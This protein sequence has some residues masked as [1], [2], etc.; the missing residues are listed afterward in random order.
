MIS[1]F[2][3]IF[4]I[5]TDYISDIFKEEVEITEKIDGSQFIFGR[6]NGEIFFRSKGATLFIDNPEKM[7]AEAIDYVVGISDIIRDNTV[8][9]CE[10]LKKP[11]H[12][13]L[14]YDRIPRNHLA[15]FGVSDSNKNFFEEIDFYATYHSI[16]RAPILYRGKVDGIEMF[17]E[18]LNTESYLGGTKIEG[19]VVKNYHRPFLLGGQPIPLMA[20]KYVSEAFKEIHQKR[21][22]GENT[23]KGRFEIF[24][25][26]FRSEA[27]WEK[28][29]QHLRDIGALEN[30]PRD[31][32]KL[33]KEI[34][35]DI[36]DEERDAIL[37]FLWKEFSPEILRCA[38]RGF[39]E[40]YKER[41]LSR[42]LKQARHRLPEAKDDK[43]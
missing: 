9:Y 25:T 24:K 26:Q 43:R 11:K 41:L 23:G 19:V 4:A 16:D 20:G 28:A 18:L 31:I 7:F 33:I 42:A 3:K 38:T 12:N 8:F 6:V 34:K 2:P 5:G 17:E 29:I 40:W 10:Y 37:K 30:S 21:W 27:R 1:A 32:G 35:E 14:K 39:P 15:L 13:T 36:S 22:K